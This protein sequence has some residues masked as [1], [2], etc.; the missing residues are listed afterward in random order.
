MSQLCLR[1]RQRARTVDLRLLRKITVFLLEKILSAKSYELGIH[2]VGTDEMAKVNETY[3]QHQGSTDVITFD[4]NES[5]DK[6]KFHGE[7]FICIDDAVAQAKQFL[8][9]W[10]SDLVRYA[11][12][13]ILHL[14]GFDDLDPVSR[15]K[16]KRVEEQ[17]LKRL[18]KQFRLKQLQRAL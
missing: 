12:H 1:N 9:I 7:I 6:N 16:M 4:Y 10:P 5:E 18:E 3:L 17:M 2:L 8:T 13:G 15:K 14:Q 11:V